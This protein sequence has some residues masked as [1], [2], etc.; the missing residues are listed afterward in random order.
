MLGSRLS[1]SLPLLLT[2]LWGGYYYTQE[3]RESKPPAQ[4][5][6]AYKRQ[7]KASIPAMCLL[8]SPFPLP[9]PLW[10]HPFLNSSCPVSIP[11][12]SPLYT[13]P[14]FQT[15]ISHRHL[16]LSQVHPYFPLCCPSPSVRFCARASLALRDLSLLLCISLEHPW[17][18]GACTEAPPW[19]P[20]LQHML[21][22]RTGL[23]GASGPHIPRG[24]SLS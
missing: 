17:E 24:H 7:D 4:G 8:Q 22:P 16:R 5:H 23:G 1:V 15:L 9:P 11:W 19:A 12:P 2:S 10:V 3:L 13:S 6:P 14:C 18:L 20:A 21:A